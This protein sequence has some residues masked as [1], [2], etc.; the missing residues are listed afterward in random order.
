MAVG[1]GLNGRL[2][3]CLLE[4][5][6]AAPGLLCQFAESFVEGT[7]FDAFEI[8]CVDKTNDILF[9]ETRPAAI[10][11]I[12]KGVKISTKELGT[13]RLNDVDVPIPEGFFGG[14]ARAIYINGA[15]ERPNG[16]S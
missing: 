1:S 6:N 4:C 5:D 10:N 12:P 11:C 14:Y 3:R 15:H 16:R 7:T 2:G 9:R 8:I 13:M